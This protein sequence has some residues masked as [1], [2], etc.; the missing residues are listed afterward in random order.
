MHQMQ[1]EAKAALQHAADTMKMYY[2]QGHDIAPNYQT[3][4]LVWLNLQNYTTDHPTKK[5][6]HTWAGPFKIVDTISSSAI[7][8]K[9]PPQQLGIHPVVSISNIHPYIPETEKIPECQTLFKP[10]P[11]IV[12][13]WGEFEIKKILESMVIYGA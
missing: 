2:D 12:D 1:E 5:L 3:G 11:G 9:L 4:D 7:K 13:R 10:T 8:L 6:N